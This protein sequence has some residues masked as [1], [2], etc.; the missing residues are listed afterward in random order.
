MTNETSDRG[1]RAERNKYFCN[2]RTVS[3]YV[4]L[5]LIIYIYIMVCSNKI[6]KMIIIILYYCSVN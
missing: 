5:G 6:M 2:A 3:K 4:K 1:N